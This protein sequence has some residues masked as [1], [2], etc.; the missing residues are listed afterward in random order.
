M[1]DGS[2]FVDNWD[3]LPDQYNTYQGPNVGGGQGAFVDNWDM[4]PDEY[5]TYQEPKLIENY[6]SSSVLEQ[7]KQAVENAPPQVKSAAKGMLEKLV[8]GDTSGLRGLMKLGLPAA[9]VAGL[10]EKNTNPLTGQVTSAANG[11]LSSAGAF[12]GMSPVGMQP[13]WQKAIDTANANTGAWKPYVDK[14]ATYTNEA[15]GGLPSV[16][17][18]QYMN[19]YLDSVLTPALREINLAS[20]QERMRL[21]HLAKVSGNDTFT[22]GSSSPSAYG[23]QLDL[24]NKNRMQRIGDTTANIYKGAF[25]TATG[26]ATT[27]LNRKMSAGG[28]FNTLANTVGTQGRGDVT[29]LAGAGDLEAKP[30]ENALTHAAD[31]SKLYTSV[32]PGT[33]SAITATNKPSVL[34]QAVGAFGALNAANKQGWF[35]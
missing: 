16:N 7:I 3:M 31:S 10:L 20:D 22:P 18:S 34:G 19:P 12:A 8:A 17:L 32:I 23:V 33:S 11:A 28:A 35:D 6:G 1:S 5:K 26:L 27:D 2:W 4:L 29:T 15:A 13:S 24:Q 21:N 30:K 25:D 14:A 9:L